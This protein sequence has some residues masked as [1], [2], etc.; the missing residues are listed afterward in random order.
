MQHW[1]KAVGTGK[2]G[3]RDL[4][5]D[6]AVAAAHAVA[7]GE[8]TEIQTAAFLMAC[9]M[10]GESDDEMLAF[11]DVFRQYS[12]PFKSYS[13]A[14]NCAGPY[15]GRS[16]FPITIPVSLLMASVGVPQV[17]HGS[18]ALPPKTGTSIKS[19]LE[20]IGVFTDL[21][22]PQWEQICSELHIGFI[23]TEKI[24]PPMLNIRHV[25]EHMGLRTLMNTVEK[26]INPVH[27]KNMIIGVNHRTAMAHLVHILPRAGFEN[28]YIVQGIE[29][30][31]DLP[32]YKNSMIRKV[33]AYGDESMVIDPATFGF[34]GEPLVKCSL[35]EQLELLRRLVAGDDSADMK[36]Y[37]D[38]VVFNAG[39]R[40]YWFDKVGTYEEGFQLAE[41][42]LQRKEAAKVLKK[43][44]ERSRAYSSGAG[45]GPGGAA[46]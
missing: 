4:T 34:R 18:E 19:L 42:L 2:K 23:W 27:A 11:I 6:E 9:R 40:L 16:Y 1:I 35:E 44:I 3:S 41:S 26:V 43:W 37:R 15:N 20:G 22:V 29:G 5:Y 14:I 39:L 13:G 45:S 7:R 31:E 10:K 33:T 32:V 30:S 28:A 25:R 21:T 46:L 17:L 24:C 36:L 12:L 38:H 8:S